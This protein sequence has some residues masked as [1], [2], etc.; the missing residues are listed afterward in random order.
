M[1]SYRTLIMLAVVL[2]AL[3]VPVCITVAAPKP[4]AVVDAGV[5]APALTVFP[6]TKYNN[7]HTQ[8]AYDMGAT[9]SFIVEQAASAKFVV[10]QF[11]VA[12][13]LPN[14][15][16]RAYL[17]GNGITAGNVATAGPCT[18]VNTFTTD[19]DGVADWYYE[20]GAL[21]TGTY[22]WAV[23]INKIAYYPDT[24]KLSVN[25]TVLISDNLNFTV[26]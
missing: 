13:L 14:A 21:S 20:T 17:D 2:A 8:E 12:G 11:S 1:R 10:V 25:H 6:D 18:L 3:A 15:T 24:T 16:Y 22:Q 19:A 9:G 4:K 26:N 7:A 23:Y 5:I